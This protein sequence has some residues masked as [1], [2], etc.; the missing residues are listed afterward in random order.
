MNYYHV[1]VNV[2]RFRYNIKM[3][4]VYLTNMMKKLQEIY[5]KTIVN[6]QFSFF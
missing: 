1:I 6:Q 4:I 3:N 5:I 2:D